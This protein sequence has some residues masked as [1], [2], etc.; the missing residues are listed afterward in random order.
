MKKNIISFVLFV[1]CVWFN[2]FAEENSSGDFYTYDYE[3]LLQ[4]TETNFLYQEAGF[5]M[6][7]DFTK[8]MEGCVV[9]VQDNEFVEPDFGYTLKI[10][11]T[12]KIYSSDNLS[13]S[14]RVKA[15][16]EFHWLGIEETSGVLRNILVK[17]TL[18]KSKPSERAS[19]EFDGSFLLKDTGTG[20]EQEVVIH[21]GLYFW[22]YAQKQ[23]NDFNPWPTIVLPDGSISCKMTLTT[24]TSMTGMQDLIYS[25]EHITKGQV[26]PGSISLQSITKTIGNQTGDDSNEGFFYSDTVGSK[27]LQEK[28]SKKMDVMLKSS[29]KNHNENKTVHPP[30]WYEANWEDSSDKKV[31]RGMKQ[32]SDK[33]TALKLAKIAAVTDLISTISIDVKNETQSQKSESEKNLYQIV[34]SVAKQ[35]IDYNVINTHFDEENCIAYVMVEIK[36]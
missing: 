3:L 6:K 29:G 8:K 28:L 36:E 7:M 15:N 31:G 20:R 14:G 27:Q 22:E 10:S 12:G 34:E 5:D 19:R 9:F 16:G 4:F 1:S 21:D 13:I 26:K 35:N 17:G 25:T 30:Y 32:F 11:N 18:K 2:M 23:E 33:E 24:R